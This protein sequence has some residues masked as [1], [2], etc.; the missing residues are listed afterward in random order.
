MLKQYNYLE[1]SCV[2][3][4]LITESDFLVSAHHK[5]KS[6]GLGTTLLYNIPEIALR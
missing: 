5:D 6:Q 2:K 4:F 3:C 1:N